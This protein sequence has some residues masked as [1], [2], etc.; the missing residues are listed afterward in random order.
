MI[1]LF[2]NFYDIFFRDG[3]RYRI[4]IDLIYFFIREPSF[5]IF[6]KH[7]SKLGIGHKDSQRARII[8][9]TSNF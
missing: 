9:D 7:R 5:C 6:I 8:I 4:T 2:R 1:E 3:C